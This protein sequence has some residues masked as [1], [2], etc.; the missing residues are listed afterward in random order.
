[1][2]VY[3]TKWEFLEEEGLNV[4]NVEMRKENYERYKYDKQMKIWDYKSNKDDRLAQKVKKDPDIVHTRHE[5]ARALLRLVKFRDNDRVMEPC[6]GKGAFYDNFPDNVTKFW[7]EKN[8]S[9]DYMFWN[10]TVDITISNPP[11]VPRKLFWLFQQ[12]AMETTEREIWWLINISSM[13]V[14]TQRRIEEMKAL[15]W[16]INQFNITCDKR[17][18]GRYVF[19]KI[20]RIKSDVFRWV[21]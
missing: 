11:F 15:G 19:L 14:F 8:E 9:R 1:M 4:R 12:K 10:E 18:F 2:R 17:W 20:D 21:G 7:C 16:Y 3:F 6:K 13:N 5:H